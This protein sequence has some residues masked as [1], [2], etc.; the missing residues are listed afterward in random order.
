MANSSCRKS[1]VTACGNWLRRGAYVKS[2]YEGNMLGR[3]V[4]GVLPLE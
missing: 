2:F 4:T 1:L 3:G